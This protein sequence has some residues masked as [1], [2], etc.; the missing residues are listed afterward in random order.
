MN[1]T[2]A[3]H[4]GVGRRHLPVRERLRRLCRD[5]EISI[6]PNAEDF[7]KLAMTRPPT[8]P[9]WV[10][11]VRLRPTRVT[12]ADPVEADRLTAGVVVQ[13]NALAEQERCDMQVDL[14]DQPQLERLTADGGR[15][16]S[17]RGSARPL[18]VQ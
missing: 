14:V 5:G 15:N 7:I 6:V 3:W 9:L 8:A 2:E 4:V 12:D 13:P 17:S 10:G 1:Q 16:T 11:S 18:P